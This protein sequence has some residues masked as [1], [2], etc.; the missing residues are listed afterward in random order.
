MMPTTLLGV[1]LIALPIAYNVLFTALARSFD[2]PGILRQDPAEVLGRFARGGTRL[3]VTWWALMLTALLLVPVSA[4]LSV[5][6]APAG[7]SIAGLS[8]A[9]G[10]TAGLVQAIGLARWPFLVPVLARRHA[11]ATSDAERGTVELV[12]ET[13]HRF[14]GVAVG[15]HLGYLATA[16]WTA[17]VGVGLIVSPAGADLLGWAGVAIGAVLAV[18]SL[19]FVGRAGDRGWSVA[20]RVVPFAYIAWSVWLVAIGVALIIEA[21]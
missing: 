20:E 12:F 4:L 13:A 6:L 17:V 18:G 8:L 9:L 2:Y 21:V 11:A 16:S 19:E 5:E 3:L 10:V 1:V 7:A 15:E 14:L